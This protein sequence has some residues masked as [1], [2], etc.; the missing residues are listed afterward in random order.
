MQ[1]VSSH[2]SH[3]VINSHITKFS[4]TTQ[5]EVEEVNRSN[6]SVST[7]STFPIDNLIHIQGNIQYLCL[8]NYVKMCLQKYQVKA[9]ICQCYFAALKKQHNILV[10][11]RHIPFSP[12]ANG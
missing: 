5:L 10:Y 8:K 1:K 11:W 6:Y 12:F 7:I 3:L 4:A 2:K 9:A